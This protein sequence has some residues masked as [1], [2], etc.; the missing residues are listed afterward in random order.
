MKNYKL[1][2]I[3]LG[4]AL[5]VA[6]ASVQAQD[7]WVSYSRA[8]DAKNYPGHNFRL[9]AMVRTD[10]T[11]DSASAHLWARVD[12]EKGFGF[13]NNMGNSPIRS[14]DWRSYSISGKVDTGAT[15]LAFGLYCMYNG[16]F[17]FDDIKLE[18]ETQKNKW[19]NIYTAN[20][21]DGNIDSLQQGIQRWNSGLNDKY[22]VSVVAAAGKPGKALLVEGDSVPN[23]GANSKV[24]KFAAV[25]GIRL[26]YE[27]YGEGA[28]LVV[29][30]G[31]GGSIESAAPFY[32]SLMKTYK[33]IA[34][35]SRS[36]G[37]SGTTGEPLTYDI[38]A[39]DVNALLEQLHIDSAFV[40]GQSDGAI[41]ALLLAKD[42]PKKVKRA[43]AYSPN[44]QPDSL[45]VF[46]WALTEVRRRARE[47][48]DSKERALNQMML[49]YPNLP[50]SALASIKAP[51]L[52]MCGDRDVI[53]PEHI[54]KMYQNIP[55]SQLCI[56]PGATHGGAWEKQELFLTIM[57][58]FFNKPFSKPD[59]KD[60]FQ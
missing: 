57:N 9:S 44:I 52:M 47:S 3:I 11:D 34:I 56:L 6:A 59:T 33:V 2:L 58:D 8:I 31:N 10:V 54:L 53:R 12:K 48:P 7:N 1:A 36:Q 45:A 27:I 42:Y 5:G 28:P 14:K 16:K 55:N 18:I 26:Y 17:Y 29:L 32:P 22:S 43:V 24:G 19:K 49:D 51:I 60:W 39:S 15:Q 35:D 37:N 30:H 23:W 4:T 13:F 38:M 41:L 46:S 21:E 40:W 20:F 25:N 50:Y